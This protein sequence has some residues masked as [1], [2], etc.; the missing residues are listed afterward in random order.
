MFVGTPME[1]EYRRL[2]ASPES[3]PALV[4]KLIALEHE[5]MA[6]KDDVATIKTP[7]LIIQ[8]DADTV[9]LEH[10][11]ELFRLLGGGVMGDMGEPCPLPA[12][13]SCRRPHTRH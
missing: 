8:G 1:D 4:D 11:V 7:M 9:T 13:R 2:A 5:P 12:L 3:F 10:S 6:W